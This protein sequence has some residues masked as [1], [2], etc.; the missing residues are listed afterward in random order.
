MTLFLSSRVLRRSENWSTVLVRAWSN[1]QET[2]LFLFLEIE[3]VHLFDFTLLD[4]VRRVTVARTQPDLLTRRK[5]NTSLL[6]RR[7]DLGSTISGAFCAG[8][9]GVALSCLIN[10]VQVSGFLISRKDVKI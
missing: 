2:Y 8:I 4:L 1:G 10:F 3:H 7:A 9:V 5:K 6:A